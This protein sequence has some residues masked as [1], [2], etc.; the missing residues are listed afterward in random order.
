MII[1]TFLILKD[2][3]MY[4]LKIY[5]SEKFSNYK[6]KIISIIHNDPRMIYEISKYKLISKILFLMDC[7]QN[8]A[9]GS[10]IGMVK[11]R[12]KTRLW[13]GEEEERV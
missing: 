9:I 1:F 10:S 7:L 3:C 4:K 11:N 2:D 6:I 5:F 13:Y 12:E 8:V